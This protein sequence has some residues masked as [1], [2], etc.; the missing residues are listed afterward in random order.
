MTPGE[1]KADMYDSGSTKLPCCTSLLT[2]AVVALSA[3]RASSEPIDIGSRRE[4][5]VDRLLID[6]MVHAELRLQRP[7]Q[8]PRARSP[9]PERHY[10]TIIKDGDLFRAYWRGSDPSYQGENV[11][12]HPGETVNYAESDDGHEWTFPNLGL[13]EVGGTRDNNVILAK[14]PP[15]LTNFSPFLDTRSDVAP[16]ERYKALAGHPGPGDKRGL[17]EPGHGL[18]AFVSADG[19]HWTKKNEVIPYRPEWRHA[20]DS[21]NVSFWSEAEQRYVCYFRT[22]TSPERLRS[23][24]RTTSPDFEK[25]TTPVEMN[26]NLPGEHLYTSQTHPYFRAPHIYIALPTRFVPGRGDAPDFDMDDVNATDILLMS[27]RAGS[28]KYDR[29]FTEAFIRPGMDAARWQNRSNYV[30]QN[31]IPTSPTEMSIYH[32]SGARYVLRTDGF[33]SVHTGSE[34]GELWTK[35][36]TFSGN[37]LHLNFSTSAAGSI[38]VEIQEPD[39]TPLPGFGAA[40]CVPNY[41]DEIDRI[42]RWR[43]KDDLSSVAGRPVRLR[44]VM[45]ECDLYSLRFHS[46]KSVEDH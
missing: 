22:W 28:T 5:F 20:F 19:I 7:V 17:T 21:Q 36:L 12:G 37:Q 41:G 39:G 24:S 10:Y 25:W 15:F 6:R 2:V 45:T 14:Q 18:F 4:L 9:L 13:H 42:V 40:D 32:R 33:V 46:L 23:I 43:G 30:A 35:P 16:N 29:T 34:T 11:S 31:V 38:L 27:S 1:T 44:F 8:A 3:T 26:P